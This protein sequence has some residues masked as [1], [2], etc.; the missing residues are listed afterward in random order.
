LV[1]APKYVERSR[2]SLCRRS[3]APRL[4]KCRRRLATRVPRGDPHGRRWFRV[5]AA[6]LPR[7]ADV[8]LDPSGA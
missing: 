3:H 7:L 2:I 1:G 5:A 6:Q 8:R 4:C